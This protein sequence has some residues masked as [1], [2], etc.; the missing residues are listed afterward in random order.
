[1]KTVIQPHEMSSQDFYKILIGSVLPRPIA[2]VSTVSKDGIDNLAPFSFFTIASVVPP[3][4]CF[5]PAVRAARP[6]NHSVG[7]EKDTLIN[8]RDTGEFVVSIVSRPL[9]PQ[10][11]QSSAEYSHG[12]SEFEKTGVSPQPSTLVK[13][14]G[15]AESFV[16]IECKLRQILTLGT[17]PQGGSLILGDIVA[18]HLD[19]TVYKDGKIDIEVLDP[20]GRLGGL[21]YSGTSDRFELPRPKL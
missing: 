17:E 11:N 7:T 18:V 1:M 5:A 16:N 9:V 15:V 4:L 13:P 21:W 3:V 6:E 19:T 8:I 12:T 20:I 14:R 10:M 2:W